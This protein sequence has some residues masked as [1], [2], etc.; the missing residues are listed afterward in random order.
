MMPPL[1][2]KATETQNSNFSGLTNDVNYFLYVSW[3]QS[4]DQSN[5]IKYLWWSY[6]T[7]WCDKIK[8]CDVI[9]E[10]REQC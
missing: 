8:S 10:A 2:M 4:L 3:M 6:V 7:F 9:D 5:P 1:A